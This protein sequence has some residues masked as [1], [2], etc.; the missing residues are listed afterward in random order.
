MR[1]ER[2]SCPKVDNEVFVIV[3]VAAAADD[4]DDNKN[5]INRIK[6]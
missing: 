6:L 5:E 4:D 3:V 1:T 2:R